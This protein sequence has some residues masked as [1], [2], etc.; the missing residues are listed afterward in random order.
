[1][2]R[3]Q[4]CSWSVL[5][6]NNHAETSIIPQ[7]YSVYI[8]IIIYLSG[9]WGGGGVWSTG[10][11]RDTSPE[12]DVP[13]QAS[14]PHRAQ[15]DLFLGRCTNLTSIQLPECL[16]EIASAF[17]SKCASLE[18]IDMHLP[19]PCLIDCHLLQGN[20]PLSSILSSFPYSIVLILWWISHSLNFRHCVFSAWSE[21]KTHCL[22][23]KDA[24]VITVL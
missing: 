23:F 4:I 9:D 6:Q 18:H 3:L 24:D 11:S 14:R 5:L 19:L 21:K 17:M 2:H 1:M 10:R 16:T 12:L 7:Y 22:K 20:I 15:Q 13:T 8:N